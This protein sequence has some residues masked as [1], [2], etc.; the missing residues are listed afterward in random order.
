MNAEANVTFDVDEDAS[1]GIIG[2]YDIFEPTKGTEIGLYNIL[3]SASTKGKY[4]IVRA[5]IS[6][7]TLTAEN[8]KTTV[9][10]RINAIYCIR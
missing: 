3:Q 9:R 8:K 4:T 2:V 6:P 10:S 7:T 1:S 5:P